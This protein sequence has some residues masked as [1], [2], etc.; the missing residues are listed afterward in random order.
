MSNL[1]SGSGR[2]VNSLHFCLASLKSC[3][4]FYFDVYSQQLQ[5]VKMMSIHSSYKSGYSDYEGCIAMPDIQAKSNPGHAFSI[6]F[7]EE[8]FYGR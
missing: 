8:F 1:L 2:V 6:F 4:C 5:V 7:K 3:G